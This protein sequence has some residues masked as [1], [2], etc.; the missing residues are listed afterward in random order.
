MDRDSHP[1]LEMLAEFVAGSCRPK[2]ERGIEEH[3]AACRR[4]RLEVLR[5]RRFAAIEDDDELAVEADWDR[6]DGRLTKPPG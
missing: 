6:V 4:C 1:D 3:V 2:V 5:L